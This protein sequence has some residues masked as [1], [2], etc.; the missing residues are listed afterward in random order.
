[1]LWE[2]YPN[3]WHQ[4]GPLPSSFCWV[5]PAGDVLRRWEGGGEW[6]WS[7]YFPNLVPS[8]SLGSGSIPPSSAWVGRVCFS[9]LTIK[10]MFSVENL[11]VIIK[12]TKSQSP[13]YYHHIQTILNNISDKITPPVKDRPLPP[14][15]HGSPCLS[16]GSELLSIIFPMQWLS[17]GL[18]SIPPLDPQTQG[19]YQSFH[20]LL[21]IS[22]TLAYAFVNSHFV[23][24]WS[25][26]Q[27]ENIVYFLLALQLIPS[28]SKGIFIL[29]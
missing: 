11:K 13:F 12:P 29:Q 6:S 3:G 21:W 8:K 17:P 20:M 22:K 16:Q 9:L 28:T 14:T 5:Q 25:I 18:V 19:W 2:V 4:R 15:P 27:L 23:K 26:T 1:M 10:R 7:I 24:L